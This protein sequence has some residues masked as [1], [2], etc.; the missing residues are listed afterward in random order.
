M[1]AAGRRGVFMTDPEGRYLVPNPHPSSPN[2]KNGGGTNLTALIT[3]D[4]RVF[5]P[6]DTVSHTVSAAYR[7]AVAKVR[8]FGT[9]AHGCF[10]QPKRLLTL[11]LRL[12]VGLGDRLASP[13][14]DGQ[15]GDSQIEKKVSRFFAA[16]F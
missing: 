16:H 1:A 12:E 10:S 14:G 3:L 8:F 5:R 7:L 6:L 15:P 13:L 2:P 4:F 9:A 11:D